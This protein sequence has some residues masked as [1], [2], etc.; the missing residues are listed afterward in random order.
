MLTVFG[1][2]R[3]IEFRSDGVTSSVPCL[4][5]RLAVHDSDSAAG[6]MMAHTVPFHELR[7]LGG[8]PG[9]RQAAVEGGEDLMAAAVASFTVLGCSEL[10]KACDELH[11]NVRSV[12]ALL[13]ALGHRVETRSSILI[14][15]L[16]GDDN[17]PAA[18]T[19]EHDLDRVGRALFAPDMIAR[20]LAREI[21]AGL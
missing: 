10:R 12:S 13:A 14:E 8:D 15:S 9:M 11:R 5:V 7:H 6:S 16:E 21:E 2:V 3:L 1:L 17:F 20:W 18:I 4:E 19:A